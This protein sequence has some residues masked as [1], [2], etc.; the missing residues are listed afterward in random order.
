M[1]EQFYN[2]PA[3]VP[4]KGAVLVVHA[5]WGLTP[6]FKS[7]CERLAGEG[8]DV[9]APD[10][11]R[12]E[13]ARTI[14]Q[15][16]KLRGKMKR[17]AAQEMLLASVKELR[18]GTGVNQIG[19]VG[20][21]LGAYYGMW[22][23]SVEPAVRAVVAF[24]GMGNFDYSQNQPAFQFHFAHPDPYTSES[25]IK[26]LEKN[27]RAAGCPVDY[28]HYH[29]AGHWF[30]ESDQPAY[31]PDLAESAWKCTVSFLTRWLQYKT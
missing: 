3:G 9:L 5:W 15:A 28:Y 31:R 8:F 27:L 18:A 11:Y 19:V 23:A 16:E 14:E 4:P 6:F 21:S 2:V 22:L 1:T 13:T 29:G 26:K 20:F 12:G 24:Y 30:F 10:L 17:A 7:F 25:G